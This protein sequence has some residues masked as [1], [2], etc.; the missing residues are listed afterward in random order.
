MQAKMFLV[1]RHIAN[2]H[3]IRRS[4]KFDNEMKLNKTVNHTL[5]CHDIRDNDST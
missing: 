4:I 5:G 3:L 1:K 2:E